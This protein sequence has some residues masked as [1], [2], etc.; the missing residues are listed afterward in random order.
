MTSAN[1]DPGRGGHDG[2]GVP[3]S[4]PGFGNSVTKFVG[5][6]EADRVGS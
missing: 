2:S 1:G 5:R 6:K 3:A 4:F